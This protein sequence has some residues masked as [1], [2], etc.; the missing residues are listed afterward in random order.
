M[1]VDMDLLLKHSFHFN[2]LYSKKISNTLGKKEYKSQNII[3]YMLKVKKVS[4]LF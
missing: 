3:I 1:A 2:F 4:N